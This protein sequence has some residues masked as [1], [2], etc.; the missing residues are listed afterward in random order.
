M[1]CGLDTTRTLQRALHNARS[2]LGARATIR[3]ATA[4]GA[5]FDAATKTCEQIADELGID[6]D[7]GEVHRHDREAVDEG[8]VFLGALESSALS[9]EARARI[10]ALTSTLRDQLHTCEREV[11]R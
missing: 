7:S 9:P 3:G 6:I 10:G 1:T 2:S 4:L 11:C 8:F 5:A